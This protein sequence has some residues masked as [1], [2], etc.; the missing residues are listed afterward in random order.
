MK[1]ILDIKKPGLNN[2]EICVLTDNRYKTSLVSIF[3]DSNNGQIYKI[4]CRV[5][6]YDEIG[7]VMSFKFLHIFK[8]IEHTEDYHIRKPNVG[9]ILFK[10]E[11]KNYFLGS[12]I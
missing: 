3:S 7:T 10:L 12:K 6:P 5:S 9:N 2:P 8:P 11:D 4:P 1:K